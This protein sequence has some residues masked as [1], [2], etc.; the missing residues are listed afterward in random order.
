MCGRFTL[1]LEPEL[2]Q[3]ELGL[4]FVP[5]N[6]TSRYNIAPSQPVAIVSNAAERRL[7][8]F[9]W[10]LIPSWAKDPAIGSRMINARSETLLEKPSFRQAFQQRRCLIVADGFY[11]W[12]RNKTKGSTPYYFRVGDGELITFA[13][14]WEV[15]KPSE[16]DVIHSC[17]IITCAAN[18]LVGAHHERMPVILPKERRWDWLSKDQKPA[19]LQ[20]MLKPYPSGEMTKRAVSAVVNSPVNDVPA[21]IQPV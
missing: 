15:W 11:E 10:G 1:I 13:G 3:S 5:E 7:E 16:G 14:L 6:M 9:R 4:S 12:D 2:I 20:A 17:T 8:L 21:C 18:E 19:V